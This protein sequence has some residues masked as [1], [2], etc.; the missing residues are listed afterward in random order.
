MEVGE[1]LS[2]L[3]QVLLHHPL[4]GRWRYLVRLPPALGHLL[5]RARLESREHVHGGSFPA[6]LGGGRAMARALS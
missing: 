6:A 5:L 4:S 2:T 1:G 3:G